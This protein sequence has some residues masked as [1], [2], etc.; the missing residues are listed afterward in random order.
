[1][2]DEFRR[3]QA[4]FDELRAMVAQE[5]RVTRVARDFI[6]IDGVLNVPEAERPSHLPDNRLARYRVLFDQLKLESGVIRYEDGSVGFLRSSSGMV[7]GGSSKE[8]IW[9]KNINA[10]ELALSGSSSLKDACVP[11]TACVATRKVAPEWFI[12]LE[13]H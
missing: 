5:P 6:W 13:S 8:F 11:K 2:V 7:T 12:S 9:S 4:V 1:M 10:P 3:N